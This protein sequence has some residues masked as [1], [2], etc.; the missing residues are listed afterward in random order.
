MFSTDISNEILR[1]TAN[2]QSY[3]NKLLDKPYDTLKGQG[4]I[5]YLIIGS[6][7]LN[8]KYINNKN[9]WKKSKRR[10]LPSKS[11]FDYLHKYTH[12]KIKHYGAKIKVVIYFT[13]KLFPID[14]KPF[15]K[16][17]VGIN[18]SRFKNASSLHNFLK[19]LLKD[20]YQTARV[21][22]VDF[23]VLVPKRYFPIELFYYHFS[24]PSISILEKYYPHSRIHLEMPASEY[25]AFKG[26]FLTGLVYGEKK[27]R[28]SIYDVEKYNRSK[29]RFKKK[30]ALELVSNHKN[31]LTKWGDGIVNIEWQIKYEKLQRFRIRYLDDL[32]KLYDM[33]PFSELKL[34]DPFSCLKSITKGNKVIPRLRK[35]TIKCGYHQARLICNRKGKKMSSIEKNNLHSIYITS[36]HLQ[37][38]EYLNRSFKEGLYR[39]CN[40]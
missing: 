30:N 36:E 29:D 22:R 8:E 33:A 6:T 13:K 2:T 27:S 17:S 3:I 40:R 31:K 7:E 35:L 15:Y 25:S 19:R 16:Y 34:I 39:Y 1:K 21:N 37:L 9:K 28:L 20:G 32:H 14:G 4:I 5:D 12:K 24:V 38:S 11:N 10:Y 26:G 18:P 23:S